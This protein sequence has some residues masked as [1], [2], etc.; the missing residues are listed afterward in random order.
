[1]KKK[2]KKKKTKKREKDTHVQNVW[3]AVEGRN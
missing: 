2:K 3:R 1:M